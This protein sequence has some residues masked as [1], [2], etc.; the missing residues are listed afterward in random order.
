MTA[1][2]D[3]YTREHR[4]ASESFKVQRKLSHQRRQPR[5]A[6]Q[7]VNQLSVVEVLV[8]L[9]LLQLLL[10]LRLLLLAAAAEKQL[11]EVED[12]D[13]GD[14]RKR[15]CNGMMSMIGFVRRIR[16]EVTTT[17]YI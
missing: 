9:V 11:Q 1:D 12:E 7:L 4:V 8:L 16:I 17:R 14:A 2:R 13:D 5:R 6:N 10:L 15:V 3:A